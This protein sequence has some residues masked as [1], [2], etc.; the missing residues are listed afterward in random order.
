ML[1]EVKGRYIVKTTIC[2]THQHRPW[3]LHFRVLS[4]G[5]LS[6]GSLLVGQL[7]GG[8]RRGHSG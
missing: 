6:D 1:N 5:G 3:V 4:V 7:I 8:G 2:E